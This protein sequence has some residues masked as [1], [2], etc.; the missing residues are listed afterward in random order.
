MMRRRLMVLSLAALVVAALLVGLALGGK[1]EESTRDGWQISV[2]VDRE[3]GLYQAGE[4]V[5]FTVRVT[6]DKQPVTV[7]EAAYEI[8]L[9][10]TKGQAG[11]K[12]KLAADGGKVPVVTPKDQPWCLML[13][14]RYKPADGAEIKAEVGAVAGAEKLKPS[15]AAPEDFDAFWAEQKKK[16][17][18]VPMN[19]RL[20][21]VP[22]PIAS[23]AEQIECFDV[24]LDCLGG[25]PV[26]GY[27]A[28]PKGAK[29]HSCP[30]IISFHGA[31]A[32][33]SGLP[34]P[35]GAALRGRLGMDI[36]A[37]GSPNGKPE[38]FYKELLATGA[39]KEYWFRGIDNRDTC[40]FLGMY[41][42]LVRAME[43]L[44][45]QPEWD[46]RTLITTG[47]SQGGAQAIVAAGLDG[48]VTV[49][50]A[51][52]PALC[53]LTGQAADRAP[54][55]PIGS[56][57]LSAAEL[58]TLRYFDVSN[59]A[60]RTKATAVIRVGLVDR[61][62]WPAGVLAMCNRLQG[63]KH[64]VTSPVSGHAYSPPEDYAKASKVFD[65][66]L[67]AILAKARADAPGEN[68]KP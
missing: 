27:F 25:A 33:S 24:Q 51:S 38:E 3:D 65:A 13:V 16:L 4:T 8:T 5:T 41:L 18:A 68:K 30:A 67:E 62:C 63:D 47:S 36:N 20:T 46:G 29:P 11:G 56:R 60:A 1:P 22:P 53:D 59:F 44:T 10:G 14:A 64:M 35:A 45:S 12:V 6:K 54:G 34:G 52:L 21:P 61:T 37:H 40:Y 50:N 19:A 57:K 7:G 39:L 9:N 66:V 48:R 2:A 42:R 23:M 58:S 55:W 17:A 31:G 43:F 49:V 28:R 15:V 32:H 26:S